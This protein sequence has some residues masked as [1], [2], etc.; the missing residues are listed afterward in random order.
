MGIK[1]YAVK[2]LDELVKRIKSKPGRMAEA[3]KKAAVANNPLSIKG[4]TAGSKPPPKGLGF[5]E[6]PNNF[7]KNPMPILP[8]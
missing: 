7:V 3:G 5:S 4:F 1:K 8:S 2:K 6:P